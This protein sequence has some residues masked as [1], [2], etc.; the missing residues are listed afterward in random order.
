MILE[1][2]LRYQ[3]EIESGSNRLSNRWT[4]IEL[5]DDTSYNKS[6]GGRGGEAEEQYLR[7]ADV[8]E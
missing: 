2:E 5:R 4:L 8:R 6:V 3:S 1:I 7:T